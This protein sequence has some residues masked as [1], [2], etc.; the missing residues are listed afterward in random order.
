MKLFYYACAAARKLQLPILARASLER[1][2]AVRLFS[3]V[4]RAL[5]VLS[6]MVE[7]LPPPVK[8]GRA[9]PVAKIMAK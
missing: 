2:I 7:G 4:N 6:G 5:R 8:K 1:R 3:A 9:A